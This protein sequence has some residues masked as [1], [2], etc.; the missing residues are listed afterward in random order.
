MAASLGGVDI[1]SRGV[2]SSACEKGVTWRIQTMC[3]WL[4]DLSFEVMLTIERVLTSNTTIII[5]HVRL[6]HAT[7]HHN[8]HQRLGQ[9][10]LGRV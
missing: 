1:S 3:E 4:V 9:R 2:A 8:T 10:S 6:H 5:K 7:T